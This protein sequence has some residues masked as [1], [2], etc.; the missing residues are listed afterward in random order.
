MSL[1]RQVGAG[2]GENKA[3]QFP[4]CSEEAGQ[5]YKGSVA[6]LFSAAERSVWISE[7]V[8][9][10]GAAKLVREVREGFP[11]RPMLRMESKA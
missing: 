2:G 4:R 7:H 3:P 11:G 1:D 10:E 6:T 9:V 5:K 8:M